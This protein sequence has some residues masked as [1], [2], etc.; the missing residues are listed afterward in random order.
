MRGGEFAKRSPRVGE[1]IQPSGGIIDA[2][3]GD[4]ELV[5]AP[6]SVGLQLRFL[7]R[8][9]GEPRNLLFQVVDLVADQKPPVRDCL[10]VF[11]LAQKERVVAY[12]DRRSETEP[13]LVVVTTRHSVL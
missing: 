2:P 12:R 11:Q 4:D 13:L 3:V 7:E 8:K 1:Y 6:V 5:A 10:G 9:R